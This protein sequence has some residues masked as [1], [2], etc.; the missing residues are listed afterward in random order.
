MIGHVYN[1]ST[2]ETEAWESC[3]WDQHG[4]KQVLN[5]LNNLF[6]NTQWVIGKVGPSEA[7]AS[8]EYCL[9]SKDVFHILQ[10]HHLWFRD[11]LYLLV[12]KPKTK[13]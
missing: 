5:K 3:V 8:V 7:S 9:Y 10:S 13:D 6:K 1:P 2:H 4:L 11:T 12:F